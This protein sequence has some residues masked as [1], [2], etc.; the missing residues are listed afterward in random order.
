MTLKDIMEAQGHKSEE[1]SQ[2]YLQID[3]EM[4]RVFD[5]YQDRIDEVWG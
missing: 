4:F 1:M 5:Q 3:P 2:Y